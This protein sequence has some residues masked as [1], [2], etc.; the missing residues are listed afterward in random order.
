MIQ[1]E[2]GNGQEEL[3]LCNDCFEKFAKDHPEVKQG[4]NINANNFLNLLMSSI[5]NLN[6]A[7]GIH[8]L[9]QGGTGDA[10][11]KPK[12]AP[13]CNRCKTTLKDL[14]ESG[15]VGCQNCYVIFHKEIDKIL[16]RISGENSQT[17]KEVIIDN[18]QKIAILKQE[19]TKAVKAEEYEIAARLRDDIMEL[20]N[21]QNKNN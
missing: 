17:M 5:N 16:L 15:K 11:A 4:M 13:V 21:K 10:T 2:D 8:K 14:R 7:G 3:N 12:P 1:N 18:D 20:E 6:N 19:L 9:G